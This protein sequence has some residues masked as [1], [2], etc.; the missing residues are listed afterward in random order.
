MAM[1]KY[2][3][4]APA[5]LHTTLKEWGKVKTASVSREEEE[6]RRKAQQISRST[7]K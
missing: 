6:E 2:G 4:A 1:M 3:A 5:T 7:K